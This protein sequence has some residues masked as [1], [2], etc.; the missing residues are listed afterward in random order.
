MHAIQIL[1][2]QLVGVYAGSSTLAWKICDISRRLVVRRR[3][4]HGIWTIVNGS[5][6]RGE[7]ESE[8]NIYITGTGVCPHCISTHW[9]NYIK[10]LLPLP[11][12]TAHIRLSTLEMELKMISPANIY[13][14]YNRRRMIQVYRINWKNAMEFN[15]SNLFPPKNRLYKIYGSVPNQNGLI[16]LTRPHICWNSF[17]RVGTWVWEV[18][19][20]KYSGHSFD[21]WCVFTRK[22]VF[23]WKFNAQKY[24]GIILGS[25]KI[26]LAFTLGLGSEKNGVTTI[27]FKRPLIWAIRPKP[28]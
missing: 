16:L 27:I 28:D 17:K 18:C 1:S 24:F 14:L 7:C 26:N 2:R 13:N 20:V 9:L 22:N 5:I 10:Y 11:Y 23:F 6:I 25:E 4:G 8:V 3:N 15:L 19:C 12:T 21:C